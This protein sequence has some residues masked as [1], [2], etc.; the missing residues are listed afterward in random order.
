M[1]SMVMMMAMASG[2]DAPAFGGK[3]FA[4]RGGGCTGTMVA[5]A[6]PTPCPPAVPACQA[7]AA[8]ETPCPPPEANPMPPIN[9]GGNAM[10]GVTPGGAV[11]MPG[12]TPAKP[13]TPTTPPVTPAKPTTPD[14]TPAKPTTPDV[15]PAKPTTPPGVTPAKPA[16][17]PVTPVKDKEDE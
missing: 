7:P 4:R 14:V 6:C 11:P 10:P 15:T 9:G 2:T 1:F 13:M 16:T 8:C 5:P 17:P 3:L 12:V